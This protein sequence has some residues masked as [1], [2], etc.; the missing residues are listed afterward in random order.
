[1][2][3]PFVEEVVTDGEWSLIFFSNEFSHGVLKRVGPG[4]FRVQNDFGGT[5]VALPPPDQALEVA[6]SLC[7]GTSGELVY[8]RVDGVM[9]DGRFLLME[10]E[11]IEPS[12]FLESNPDATSRFA[13][14]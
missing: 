7:V 12:L 6:Q 10:L 5:S 8:A 1:L 2:I 4:D 14:A 13:E 11:L 3:Q 9:V